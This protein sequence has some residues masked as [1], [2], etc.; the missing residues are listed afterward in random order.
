LHTFHH[1]YARHDSSQWLILCATWHI[2]TCNHML[3]R[4][5]R[6]SCILWIISRCD[7]THPY[8]QSYPHLSSWQGRAWLINTRHDSVAYMRHVS[9]IYM[10]NNSTTYM[11][12]DSTIYIQNDS[13]TYMKNISIKYMKNDSITYMRNTSITYMRY[14]STTP[15]TRE[16][17]QSHT[18]EMTQLHHIHET[19]LNQKKW[20]NPI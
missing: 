5:Q 1:I 16:M 11:R 8:L 12:N 10:R 14:Y 9:T 17:T 4:K 6:D 15:H 19:W 7:V 2:R 18:R 3:Q 13:I 20:L